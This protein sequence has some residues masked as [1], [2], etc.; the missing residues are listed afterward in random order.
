[1]QII[2]RS[3]GNV[4]ADGFYLDVSPKCGGIYNV[5]NKSRKTIT[6]KSVNDNFNT[7]SPFCNFTFVTESE[8]TIVTRLIPF[9][10]YFT[11][12][13]DNCESQQYVNVY[14]WNK[15][16]KEMELDGKFCVR[17]LD[18]QFFAQNEMRLEFNLREIGIMESIK[19]EY[20][21]ESCRDIIRAPG[22]IYSPKG[23]HDIK[24]ECEWKIEAPEN[25]QIKLSFKDFHVGKIDICQYNL[26]GVKVLKG[27]ETNS[28]YNFCGKFNETKVTKIPANTGTISYFNPYSD[29]TDAFKVNVEFIR[30]CDENIDLKDAKSLRVLKQLG[31]GTDNYECNYYLSAPEGFRIEVEFEEIKMLMGEEKCGE[32][33]IELYEGYEVHQGLMLKLCRNERLKVISPENK[34]NILAKGNTLDFKV[35]LNLK[36][37]WCESNKTII[38]SD[39]KSE[40][41]QISSYPANTYCK[42]TI[43]SDSFFDIVVDYMDLQPRSDI[44]GECLDELSINSFAVSFLFILYLNIIN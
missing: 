25:Y 41:I 40:S 22:W 27:N 39:G 29:E 3:D 32:T 5:T 38:L 15:Y 11:I 23:M 24:E 33:F 1:M 16:A 4:T 14:K 12:S 26:F 6:F 18:K 36:K 43:K 13:E 28:H 10:L 19:I 8:H 31:N 34:L 21:I 30:M 17:L 44:T 37:T 2:F 42:W 9:K 7:V 35:A 20:Y